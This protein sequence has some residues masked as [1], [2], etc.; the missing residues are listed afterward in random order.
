[1]KIAMIGS[2]H[3]HLPVYMKAV[4]EQGHEILLF[5]P[6]TARA[7]EQAEQY[8]VTCTDSLGDLYA[9]EISFAIVLG[10]HTEMPTFISQTIDAGIPFLAEKPAGLDASV[11]LQ[12]ADRCVEKGLFNAAA[13]SMRWDS[14]MKRI[15]DLIDSGRL[16]RIARVSVSYFAGPK[17]RY[18][19]SGC[20]WV[21]E[22]DIAGGG[23]LMNVGTHVIDLLHYWGFDL[24]Y[25]SGSASWELTRGSIEDTA[26]LILKSDQTTCLVESGYLAQNPYDGAHI[27]IF[28]E[29]ANLEYRLHQLT[30][31]WADGSEDRFVNAHPEP[32]D[33]ML[34]DLIA[35]AGSDQP[36][37][38]T[39][40]DMAAM[41]EI[42]NTFY[43]DLNRC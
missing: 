31:E 30:V 19:T 36:S 4:L 14:A 34:N 28:A 6:D 10:K 5:D 8:H 17:S 21:L 37:P 40:Y 11:V 3:W 29:H 12:L 38:A 33:E 43:G 24:Q 41:L 22:K 16:G 9:S 18:H 23:A 7:A 35:K 27:T 2:S 13:F 1:M 39:L 25:V 20:P 15:K 42:C 32:R 26:T